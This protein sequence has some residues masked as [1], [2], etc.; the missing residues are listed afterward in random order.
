VSVDG[1]VAEALRA[2]LVAYLRRRGQAVEDA[3]DVVQD[4]FVR[5]YRAGHALEAPDARPLLFVIARNLLR[6]RWKVAGREAGRR[7]GDDIQSLDEGPW[8]VADPGQGAETRLGQRQ[9]LAAAAAVIRA[10]P[11]RTREAFLLHRFEE[12][13]YRQIAARLGVSVSMVEKLIAEALRQLKKSR[14]D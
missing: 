13:T 12:M 5:L 11:R 7:V 9:D 8:A 4:A 2:D 14:S 6:D 1:A 3:E 10:L